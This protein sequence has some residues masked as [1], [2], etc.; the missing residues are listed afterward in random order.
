[1]PIEILMPALSPT[2]EHGNLAKWLK[3]EGDVVKIGDVIAEIETDK[4]TMELESIE[5]GVLGKIFVPSGSQ[6]VK[7][8]TLI[9]LLLSKGEDANMIANYN[10]SVNE[11]VKIELNSQIKQ[12]VINDIA[13]NISKEESNEKKFASPLARRIA[14][15][16][17][18]DI[19][20]IIGSG[21]NGRVIKFDVENIL[22]NK[23]FIPTINL[24]NTPREANSK[25]PHSNM[26]KVIA[27]RLSESKQTVPHFY[28]TKECN[29]DKLMKL[30]QEVNENIEGK[31]SINDFIIKACAIALKKIPEVNAS[32]ASDAM[33]IYNNVD[34]SV[35]VS[36]D[37]GLVTPIIKDADK[38]SVT[39]ISKQ[40][41]QLAEKARS[42]K[43]VPEDYQGGGFTISNMGMYGIKSFSAIINPPQSC[44]LAI[45]SSEK[46]AIIDDNDNI[47]IANI[48]SITLSCDHRVVDGTLAAKWIKEFAD[49]IENPIRLLV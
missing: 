45:G 34:I 13:V 20:S 42:G 49:N 35:A 30:R 48:V 40:M 7:V 41:K 18:I 16:A 19:S 37:D 1:M 25:K 8:K 3:K 31:I 46:R 47:K 36:I 6:E 22:E 28:L 43:L 44:I 15:Q 38:K 10:S 23:K 14:Q 39:E 26:R 5:D 32:W 12:E 4:A 17:D 2:M 29:L 33:I 21:P 24:Q 27:A 11:P 9:A